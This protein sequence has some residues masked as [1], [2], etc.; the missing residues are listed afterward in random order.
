[1]IVDFIHWLGHDSF[2][3]KDSDKILYIDPWKLP[4]NSP[5][6]D[7]IFVTHSHYDHFSHP[8]IEKI[9][10]IDTKIIAPVDVTDKLSGNALPLKPNQTIRLDSLAVEAVPAYNIDKT[11][12]PKEKEWLGFIIQLSGGLK[13]YHAGD[14][15]FI[16]EM[17]N[18]KAL[19]IAR[20]KLGDPD[21]SGRR[22]PEILAGNESVLPVDLVIEAI[23]QRT[24]ENLNDI[25][26][27]IE[28]SRKGL[29]VTAE[30]SNTTS[31][32][33]V[34][35]GGDL[36][37]GGATAVQAVADGLRAANEIDTFLN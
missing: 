37:N 36:I 30:D 17:K 1:M 7:Y 20:T 11:F 32:K 26:N 24:P 14:T 19:R 10:K 2:L 4:T 6:A 22:R 16:P 34:F 18:I 25:L 28:L 29:V 3:I 5:K 33:G 31:R 15:D 12:H 23:G 8:D 35:A 21:E 13:I 9:R 27:G